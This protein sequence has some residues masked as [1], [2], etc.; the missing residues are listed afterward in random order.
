VISGANGRHHVAIPAETVRGLKNSEV[1][2]R[3]A[4]LLS[5][6][7]LT[8]STRGNDNDVVVFCFAEPEDAETFSKRFGGGALAGDR[9]VT[10]SRLTPERR[11]VNHSST[12]MPLPAQFIAAKRNQRR[13]Q[14]QF[15]A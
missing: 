9:A 7:P 8:H 2:F 10:M 11:L 12:P 1:I 5:A 13:Y 14:Q 3:A 6:T 15:P 4:G